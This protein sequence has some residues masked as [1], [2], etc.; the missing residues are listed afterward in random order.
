MLKFS[1]IAVISMAFSASASAQSD[2]GISKPAE[3]PDFGELKT[4]DGTILRDCR[5]KRVNADGLVLEHSKGVSHVSFFDLP[6]KIQEQYDFDPVAALGEY[7][8]RIA[9]ERARRK[10][11]VLQAEEQ[12]AEAIR[13]AATDER[14]EIAKSEWVPAEGKILL[15][16][17]GGFFIQANRIVMVPTKVVSKLGFESEGPPERK[18]SRFGPGLI[19]L[20]IEKDAV[21]ESGEVWQG[22]IDPVTVQTTHFPPTGAHN[23]PIHRAITLRD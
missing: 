19:F 21:V 18:L 11:M 14:Y 3:E 22:Y 16:R 2:D 4:T 13:I 23:I 9:A 20:K 7:N 12:K 1:V 17:D 15:K 10:E 6:F 8:T 5:V